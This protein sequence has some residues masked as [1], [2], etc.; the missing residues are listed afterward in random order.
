MQY[1]TVFTMV[2]TFLQALG[3]LG[4][5]RADALILYTLYFIEHV[6]HVFMCIYA[7]VETRCPLIL[8]SFLLLLRWGLSFEPRAG[9]LIQSRQLSCPMEPMS[10]Y[11]SVGI[12]G[13]LPCPP[14]IYMGTG[15]SNPGSHTCIEALYP[16]NHCPQSL[17]DLK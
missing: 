5:G 7:P 12:I 16:L 6:L 4:R 8:L 11:P 3:R 2:N 9:Q 14:S 1:C 13:L 10:H 17:Y 15:D